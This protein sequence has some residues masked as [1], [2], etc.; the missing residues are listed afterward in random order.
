MDILDFLKTQS[1][2]VEKADEL[3]V[4]FYKN[5]KT[6]EEVDSKAKK[7]DKTSKE[8]EEATSQLEAR[9]KEIEE[10]NSK[11]GE[12][13]KSSETKIA[14]L[15]GNI[16]KYK[17]KDTLLDKG[18]KREYSDFVLYKLGQMEGEDVDSNIEEVLKA[19]PFLKEE[20]TKVKTIPDGEGSKAGSSFNEK[21]R[22]AIAS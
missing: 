6:V 15:E 18:I 13:Q 16:G 17:L 20:S 10:L 22:E 12:A 8:L 19:N 11:L 21:L 14:E 4:E 3:K 9:S 7:L 2:E 5:F 1:I